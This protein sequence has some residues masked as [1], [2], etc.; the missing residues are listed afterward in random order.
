VIDII[1]L[2]DLLSIPMNIEAFKK[3]IN[4]C[5][6]IGKLAAKINRKPNVLSMWLL[7]ENMPSEE[8][9]PV[10]EATGWAVTPHELE[11]TLYPY[12]QDALP[13][14]LRHAA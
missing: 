7:R 3:A 6:G 5:D 13:K 11:P 14:N 9:I 2:R 1:T 12:P 4:C 10:C 8:V